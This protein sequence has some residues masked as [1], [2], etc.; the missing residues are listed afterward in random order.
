MMETIKLEPL[1]DQDQLEEELNDAGQ[2]LE[3]QFGSERRSGGGNLNQ[4]RKKI[5][6]DKTSLAGESTQCRLC[7]S[8]VSRLTNSVNN[9]V[10]LDFL[11]FVPGLVSF[12]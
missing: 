2:L 6:V 7:C 11:N 9:K 12:P 3:L 8:S 10:I 5:V 4:R 1:D